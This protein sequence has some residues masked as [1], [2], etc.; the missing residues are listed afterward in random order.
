MKKLLTACILI[1]LL[2]LLYFIESSTNVKA[3]PGLLEEYE[4]SDKE[5]QEFIIDNRIV[6]FHQRKIDNVIVEGDYILYHF[7]KNTKEFLDKRMHWRE[8]LPEKLYLKM[9][10]EGK[11][12]SLV[13]GVALYGK[14]YIISPES[15]GF[16]ID[17]TPKNPC[18]AVRSIDNNEMK[19]TIIDAV[20]GELLG[21]GVPPP[22][23]AF[24]LSGPQYE[25][26]CS[27]TWD[28]FYEN[29]RHWFNIMGYST[30]KVAWPTKDKI[31]SHIQ[32]YDTAMFYEVAH[33]GS[34]AF[35][36]GCDG[37]EFEYTDA[38]EIRSW[39]NN[40][41]KIP[42]SF[43]GSCDGM[44]ETNFNTLAYS[45]MKG[46]SSGTTAVGYCNFGEPFC[47]DCVG[48]WEWYWQ[49]EL[50][51]RMNN[52]YTVRDAFSYATMYY[53]MCLPCVRFAGD[54]SFRVVPV[55]DRVPYKCGDVVTDSFVDLDYDLLDCPG[56]GL[57]IGAD[58]VIVDCNY[59]T[60]SGSG[61]GIGININGKNNV[62]IRYCNLRDF[63][64]GVSVVES[65]DTMLWRV[66][67][68]ENNQ[69]GIEIR[70]SEDTGVSYGRSCNAGIV[71]LGCFNSPGSYGHEND[72]AI[73]AG[74]PDISYDSCHESNLLMNPSY[75]FDLGLDYFTDWDLDDDIA[76]NN[77]ADG[78]STNIWFYH[79][80]MD[81][82]EVYDGESSI[83]IYKDIEY[84]PQAYVLQDVAI[85][86]GKTYRIT[87]YVKTDCDDSDCY[88]TIIS[89]C[90]D[91]EHDWIYR[92]CDLKL[93]ELEWTKLYGDNDWTRIRFDVT[94]DNEDAAYV[95]VLCYNTPSPAQSGIGTV[96][97]DALEVEEV[98]GGYWPV[99]G[100]ALSQVYGWGSGV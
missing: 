64:T 47:D 50:F 59:H 23:T 20:T 76:G 77:L 11:A 28:D 38:S 39:I 96:W 19:I 74:C 60:I 42:F 81:F 6:Y 44:C 54:E 14:L 32:S 91:S 86:Y 21:Y 85:E 17:P 87:G 61:E 70:N 67:T 71:D 43:V 37:G 57:I 12:R 36:G 99:G 25:N 93:E 92:D 7:D 24:S 80:V 82:E 27:G 3:L 65:F 5:F 13:D 8:D 16:P 35:A 15:H 83:R 10:S 26:P 49:N 52:G 63:D 29:A 78:W 46:S 69:F 94:A 40:Y 58:D 9:I 75:E 2:L 56:D 45:L 41:P 48:H 31:M 79:G 4:S 53:P 88:G 18:W 84:D 100:K 33:G 90:I 55:V 73:T 72:F 68:S 66:W 62:R 34:Y 51:R 97:C 89:E 1:S 22:Y 98:N 30:E 95:R